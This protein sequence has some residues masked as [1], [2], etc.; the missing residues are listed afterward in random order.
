MRCATVR[1]VGGPPRRRRRCSLRREPPACGRRRHSSGVLHR[2]G[3]GRKRK[4]VAGLSGGQVRTD[5]R[6]VALCAHPLPHIPAQRGGAPHF[7]PR[8]SMFC[9]NGDSCNTRYKSKPFWMSSNWDGGSWASQ[10][11]Q[12]GIFSDNPGDSQFATANRVYVKVLLTRQRRV[13]STPRPALLGPA[14]CAGPHGRVA[15]ALPAVPTPRPA[16]SSTAP[17]TCGLATPARWRR[18]AATRSGGSASR[19]RW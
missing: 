8:P 5:G 4:R 11:A 10:F 7:R 9:W 1:P 2:S 6:A 14:N 3:D 19:R 13:H 15:V 18:R 12:G 16:P 17:P